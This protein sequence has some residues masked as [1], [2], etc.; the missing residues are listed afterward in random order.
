MWTAGFLALASAR[1]CWV[2]LA[3]VL[4]SGC[5]FAFVRPPPAPEKRSAPPGVQVECTTSRAAPIVDAVITAF[6]ALRTAVAVS[7]TEAD[8][9]DAPIDREVDIAAGVTL[10]TLFGVSAIYGFYATSQ[11]DTAKAAQVVE[12]GPV[13]SPG[14]TQSCFGKNVC[15]GRQSC[16]LD[17]MSWQTCEC[18]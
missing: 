17:G 6:Q 9:V 16:S 2:V 13:C 1:R 18:Q 4:L 3:A 7:S 14:A 8:Y 12:T 15:G 11:C 10:T 5:S